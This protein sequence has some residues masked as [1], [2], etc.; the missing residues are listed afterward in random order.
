[1]RGSSSAS[2]LLLHLPAESFRSSSAFSLCPLYVAKFSANTLAVVFFLK[3][4]VAWMHLVW[5]IHQ[6]C[7]NFHWGER[8]VNSGYSGSQS[9]TICLVS[10]GSV[11][12]K[13]R[14]FS[15]SLTASLTNDPLEFERNRISS[16]CHY[17]KK[18]FLLLW[19]AQKR[20]WDKV[21]ELKMITW[22]CQVWQ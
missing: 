4:F 10:S 5:R 7:H 8:V 9:S 3:T 17:Q 15:H 14:F 6:F 19:K 22:S 16:F 1:M 11:I 2:L 21:L 12:C 20:Y 13:P 18:L